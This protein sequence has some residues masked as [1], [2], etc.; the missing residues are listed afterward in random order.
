MRTT[1][2]CKTTHETAT[3]AQWH[4]STDDRGLN[5]RRLISLEVD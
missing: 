4:N 3:Q 5:Q 2:S 1:E